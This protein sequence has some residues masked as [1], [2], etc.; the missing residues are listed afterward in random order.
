M[1]RWVPLKPDFWEHENLSGSS[2]IWL[3]NTNLH[4]LMYDFGKQSGLSGNLALL[5]YSL[6]ET[7]LYSLV[8]RLE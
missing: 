1:Y 5:L 4:C 2:V 7:H 6:S 8:C 3:I